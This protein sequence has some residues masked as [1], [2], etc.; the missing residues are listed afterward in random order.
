MR[1]VWE[2]RW[3]LSLRVGT[4]MDKKSHRSILLKPKFIVCNLQ[5][6]GESYMPAF[7]SHI[8]LEIT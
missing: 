5:I 8:Q 6:I 3:V 2:M 7:A 4:Y 1:N